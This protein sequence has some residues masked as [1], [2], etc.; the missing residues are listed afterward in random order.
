MIKTIMSGDEAR[1]GVKNIPS[2][3]E[4]WGIPL[5][6]SNKRRLLSLTG[7]MIDKG[8]NKCWIATVNPEFIM[9][10]G[11]DSKFAKILQN[12][13]TVNVVDGIGLIW[14][15][16]VMRVEGWR[17]WW[18]AVKTGVKILRGELREELITGAD[19]MDELCRMAEGKGWG[20]YFLG[21]WEDR[22]KRTA[23]YFV[24]KYPKLKVVGWKAEDYDLTTKTEVLLVARGMKRQEEWISQH[25]DKLS[26]RLVMGVGRSFDYYSGDLK[27]AP[28]WLRK[29]GL[30]WLYSL[31]KEPKRWKRQLA[32]PVFILKVMSSE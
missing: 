17:R 24:K 15:K 2:N 23:D 29:M 12:Q 26:V 30:E 32:L 7:D 11:R 3:W 13:T 1:V 9:Q 16:R 22:A 5:Y 31:Y 21:G 25:F 20:V 4:I 14:A 10:A 8:Q 28:E 19:L 6:G 18:V 27:R